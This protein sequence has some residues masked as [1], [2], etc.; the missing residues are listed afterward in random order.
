MEEI[1][2]LIIKELMRGVPTVVQQV[3]D[4]LVSVVAW[5]LS[6][7]WCSGLKDPVLPQL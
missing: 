2:V 4:G 7:A 3:K 6:P 1:G 5:V